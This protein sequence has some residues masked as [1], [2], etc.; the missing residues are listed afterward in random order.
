MW[1]ESEVGRGTTFSFSLPLPNPDQAGWLQP[2]VEVAE[3]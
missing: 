1:V 2:P 3:G